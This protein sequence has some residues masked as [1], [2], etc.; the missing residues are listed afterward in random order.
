MFVSYMQNQGIR[1]KSEINCVIEIWIFNICSRGPPGALEL[2]I[3]FHEAASPIT[4][5]LSPV[6]ATS[7]RVHR[8]LRLI[9]MNGAFVT[10]LSLC[11]CDMRSTFV[12]PLLDLVVS[13]VTSIEGNAIEQAILGG[14]ATSTWPLVLQLSSNGSLVDLL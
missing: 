8:C 13:V 11:Q 2:A 1:E 10:G 14:V 6:S 9:N 12:A 5:R 4:I 3:L 7:I